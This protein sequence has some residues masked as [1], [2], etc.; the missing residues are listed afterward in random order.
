[1]W[2]TVGLMVVLF[3]LSVFLRGYIGRQWSPLMQAPWWVIGPIIAAIQRRPK[4]ETL[5]VEATADGVRFGE[6]LVPRAK[7]KSALLRREGEK[8]FVLL[9][10]AGSWGASADVEVKDDDE[11]DQLCAA[12]A[13]DAKSTVAEFA[14]FGGGAARATAR[15]VLVGVAALIAAIAAATFAIAGHHMLAPIVIVMALL[16]GM[17]ITIP[18]LVYSKQTKLRVGADGIVVKQ[19]F[20]KR[21]FVSH[22]DIEKVTAVGSDVIVTR[23]HGQQMTFA[24]QRDVAKK[25][26]QREEVWRQAESIAWRIEKA[27]QAY[28]ALAG[29]VP[30]AALALDRGDKTVAEWIEQLRRV[31][32]GANAT[33]R[34]VGLTREQLMSVVESTTAAAKA[35]LAAAVALREG[36]TEEEKP[37][38]RVA[39]DRC[40][41]PAMRERMVRVA[42]APDEELATALDEE[43]S[44]GAVARR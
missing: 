25:K 30:Q 38:I 20:A 15:S 8:T 12:L 43:V 33:F 18:A 5:R 42:F 41:E 13:L 29:E 40:V 37:R 17:L 10:G 4:I 24:V 44:D 34:D 1:M 27:R 28:Q 14:M 39:A 3:A 9:R 23:K 22:D 21:E 35:R 11:A 36:L 2:M 26:T 7:L 31:G 6:K 19:G 32:Q 16:F